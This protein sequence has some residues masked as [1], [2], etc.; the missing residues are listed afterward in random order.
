MT[1]GRYELYETEIMLLFE[2]NGI[3]M[4]DALWKQHFDVG[5]GNVLLPFILLWGLIYNNI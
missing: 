2:N 1:P 5:P 3:E 4:I